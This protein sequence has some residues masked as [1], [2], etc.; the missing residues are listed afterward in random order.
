MKTR[1]TLTE[2]HSNQPD[3][4]I[5]ALPPGLKEGFSYYLA[6]KREEGNLVLS[7]SG[8]TVLS[9]DNQEAKELLS[10]ISP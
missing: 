2:N 4:L 1:W 5:L 7:A 9:A 8:L 6:V 3:E 10:I